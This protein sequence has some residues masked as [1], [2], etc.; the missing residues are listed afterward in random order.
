MDSYVLPSWIL[1]A[2][3]DLKNFPVSPKVQES[4]E[5]GGGERSRGCWCAGGQDSSLKN[6]EG[7]HEGGAICDGGSKGEQD[8]V[9]GE[10]SAG[11]WAY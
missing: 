10:Q 1:R 8:V 5:L 4:L 7:L 2:A 11:T 9:R 6:P 3:D